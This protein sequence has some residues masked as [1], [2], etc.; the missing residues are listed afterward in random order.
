MRTPQVENRSQPRLSI[1]RARVSSRNQLQSQPLEASAADCHHALP[2]AQWH[3]ARLS[4][5]ALDWSTL[6]AIR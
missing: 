3:K 1:A 6:D 4:R 2:P 5:N